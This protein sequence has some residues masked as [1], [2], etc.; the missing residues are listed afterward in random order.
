MNSGKAKRYICE[1]EKEE[2]DRL[3]AHESTKM[4]G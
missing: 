3:H 2:K 1:K 4:C